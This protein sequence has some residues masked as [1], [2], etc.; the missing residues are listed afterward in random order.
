MFRLEPDL[1]VRQGERKWV[2]DTKWKRLN[3]ADRV[4]KYDLS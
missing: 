2:L 3:A 1:L 4:H